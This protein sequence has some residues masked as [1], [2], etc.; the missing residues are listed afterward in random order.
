M[1]RD[2]N[3]TLLATH[4]RTS[5]SREKLVKFG[6]SIIPWLIIAALL[7]VGLFIKPQPVG[8]TM[9]PPSIERTDSFYGIASPAKGVL[10]IAGNNGK[11]VRSE[12]DGLN[13]VLQT[14]P[15]RQHLQDIASWDSKRAVAVGNKGVVIITADGGA[16]WTEVSAPLSR[17]S[18]KLLRV[19]ALPEGRAWAV[20]EM[21]ALLETTD[22]GKTWERRRD[23]EDAAWNDVLFLDANN[24]WLMGEA[25]RIM[26]TTDGGKTWQPVASPVKVSLMAVAFRDAANGVAVGLEG[27]LLATHN[28]GNTWE[29]LPRAKRVPATLSP[30]DVANSAAGSGKLRVPEEAGEHL[31][32]IAWDEAQQIWLAIGNQGVWVQGDKNAEV[33]EAGR[34]DARNLAWHTRLIVANGQTYM[35]GASVGAWD[36][37]VWR[38]F[39]SKG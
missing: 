11:V 34:I 26:K 13:W 1:K 8:T 22:Y 4:P 33:W 27:S 5:S 19:K 10:W 9:Q 2:L 20:G 25:G 15:T 16:T 12:D 30:G 37:R 39:K 35:A 36:K 21:G 38:A 3:L 18:N 31:F 29:L 23:E 14:T 17:I 6:L 24:G 7:W 28:G 32:D